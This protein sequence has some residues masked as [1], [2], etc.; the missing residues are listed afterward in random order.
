MQ[1]ALSDNYGVEYTDKA[2]YKWLCDRATP[3]LEIVD[4]LAQLLGLTIPEL[5]NPTSKT[6]SKIKTIAFTDGCGIQEDKFAEMLC[7]CMNKAEIDLMFE[8]RK[9]ATPE[10][11]S[12][13]AAV[14]MGDLL[15]R[16]KAPLPREL[17]KK[18]IPMHS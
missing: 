13:R 7:E 11:I 18:M 3:P 16:T 12:V 17:Q 6:E 8:S 14:L 4:A 2:V 15:S 9:K 5:I 10:D 1:K